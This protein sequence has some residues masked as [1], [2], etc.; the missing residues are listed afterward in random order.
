[1]VWHVH[2]WFSWLNAISAITPP[3]T[4]FHK[5][6]EV[7]IWTLFSSE[8]N[9]DNFSKWYHDVTIKWVLKC[10]LARRHEANQL[11]AA[12]LKSTEDSRW[13][14]KRLGRAGGCWLVVI[15]GLNVLWGI[16]SRVWALKCSETFICVSLPD[17]KRSIKHPKASDDSILKAWSTI[18]ADVMLSLLLVNHCDVFKGQTTRIRLLL[19]FLNIV[20]LI[21]NVKCKCLHL[22]WRLFQPVNHP[23]ALG[24]DSI[25]GQTATCGTDGRLDTI[26]EVSIWFF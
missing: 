21:L 7:I 13:S 2:I 25:R 24:R 20:F 15:V 5:Q 14:S 9:T 17:S 26:Q 10:P 23:C 8:A 11:R 1:M 22:K 16:I 3:S 4:T 18:K 12:S 6:Y 19:F